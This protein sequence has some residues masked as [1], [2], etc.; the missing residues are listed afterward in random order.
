MHCLLRRQCCALQTWQRPT[1][2]RLKTKY[3]RRWGVSRPCS[4]WER[5]QPPRHDHQVG[6]A[7]H[8][9]SW[10]DRGLVFLI[11]VHLFHSRLFSHLRASAAWG[12][13][14]NRRRAIALYCCHTRTRIWHPYRT[15]VRRAPE[16]IEGLARPVRSAFLRVRTEDG[17]VKLC[18]TSTSNENNQANRAI[19]TG[20]LHA[21]PHFHTRPINVVVFHGSDREHSFSGWFP[22]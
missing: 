19:S 4:E 15:L 20:K 8:L 12:A 5:V 6:K 13:P 16:F 2:P 11:H 3:H 1:L 17:I 22:A 14:D 21:L 7:Q 9:R 10:R 18:L